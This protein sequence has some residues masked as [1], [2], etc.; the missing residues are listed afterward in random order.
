MRLGLDG[1]GG[2]SR[3]VVVVVVVGSGGGGGGPGCSLGSASERPVPG[4]EPV[5]ACPGR[6]TCFFGRDKGRLAPEPLVS[7]RIL[8]STQA[9]P[10]WQA[11]AP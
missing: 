5:K 10:T 9:H 2:G 6:G 8:G 11:G 4:P 1:G 7:I 3:G